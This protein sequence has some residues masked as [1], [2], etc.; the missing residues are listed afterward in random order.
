MP[1]TLP[2]QQ[3]HI[4]HSTSSPLQITLAFL[5][6]ILIGANDGAFGVLIPS[7]LAHYQINK[8]T[9]SLLFLASTA[10]YLTAAFNNGFLMSKLGTRTFLLVGLASI[11]L[12]MSIVAMM[13]PFP[14]VLCLFLPIGFGVAIIDAGLNSYIAGL[15]RNVALLNY[16]HAFYGTGALLG[17]LLA[18]TMLALSFGWNM[19]YLVWVG[20]CVILFAG[21]IGAFTRTMTASQH[22]QSPRESTSANGLLWSVL[23]MRVVWLAAL[24]LFFYVGA[25]TSLGSWSYSFLTA[26]RHMPLLSSGWIV[27]GYWLGLTLGRLTLA[28]AAQ[29]LGGQRLVQYCLLGVLCGSLLIWLFPAQ[30]ITAAALCL[31]GFCLGPIFPTTIALTSR[32]VSGRLLASAIGLLTSL[33]SVGAAFFPWLVGNL[34][35]HFSLDILLPYV[36]LLTI[37]MAGFWLS[38]R[39]DSTATGESSIGQ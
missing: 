33:S 20:I 7:M 3:Q 18:S 17:P 34:V 26:Q 29:K 19:V 11:G 28:R 23:R 12:S 36:L 39:R 14:V 5:A 4:E 9:I 15:P 22:E 27:S 13:P 21:V 37:A 31:T 2:E 38:L 6:F 35:Q 1:K 8:A 24:F 25:E 10:G 32:L 30:I 16:L